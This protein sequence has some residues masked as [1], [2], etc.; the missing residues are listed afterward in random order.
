MAAI[1]LVG[2]LFLGVCG[3]PADP[4]SVEVS[5]LPSYNP[6]A[7][8]VNVA[9]NTL[10]VCP[11]T[12]GV[13]NDSAVVFTN[14]IDL[15]S[16]G[17]FGSSSIV[18]TSA[19]DLI[20]RG[21]A[22]S[23]GASLYLVVQPTP[24]AITMI[25]NGYSPERRYATM[26]AFVCNVMPVESS[27]TQLNVTYAIAEMYSQ[28]GII[29]RSPS[30]KPTVAP[31][32]SPT[33]LPTRF[34]TYAPTRLPTN[35]PTTACS[36]VYANVA[37]YV[38]TVGM[39]P[40]A[41]YCVAEDFVPGTATITTFFGATEGTLD[42]CATECN[43]E[44]T[45]TGFV[46]KGAD[47]CSLTSGHA[48]PGT[49]VYGDVFGAVRLDTYDTLNPTAAPTYS[50]TSTPTTLIAPT[51]APTTATPTNSPTPSNYYGPMT[52]LEC[53]HYME[54]DDIT[55]NLNPVGLFTVAY[56]YAVSMSSDGN[57]LAV[58]MASTDGIVN[59]YGYDNREV[60]SQ[61]GT[62]L[63]ASSSFYFGVSVALAPENSN[64]LV[65][66]MPATSAAPGRAQYFVYDGT[67]WTK[68]GPDLVG[69]G[70]T[71]RFFGTSVA[72]TK[73]GS[74][75]AVGD[76]GSNYVNIYNC[77]ITTGC[78]FVSIISNFEGGSTA[79]FG[80]SIALSDVSI[81]IGSPNYQHD[82]P[83]EGMV[84]YYNMPFDDPTYTEHFGGVTNKGIGA[85][86]TISRDG[87]LYGYTDA[88]G[89]AYVFE[90][91]GG[92]SSPLG[93]T[94]ISVDAAAYYS[95]VKL[96]DDG[97]ILFVGNTGDNS[98]TAYTYVSGDWRL[99]GIPLSPELGGLNYRGASIAASY[100]GTTVVSG[101]A[102]RNA[103]Y[104]NEG[105]SVYRQDSSDNSG[106]A[107]KYADSG[108]DVA[109]RRYCCAPY[110]NCNEFFV[111]GG[112]YNG[113][114]CPSTPTESRISNNSEPCVYCIV[115]NEIT[116]MYCGNTAGCNGTYHC[117]TSA[118]VVYDACVLDYTT[119]A[120]TPSTTLSPTSVPTFRIDVDPTS[121]TC[122]TFVLPNATNLTTFPTC[123]NNDYSERSSVGTYNQHTW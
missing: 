59:V 76:P 105:I 75:V 65:V 25:L 102:R 88:N 30:A 2:A 104:E 66:G 106:W 22:S 117:P 57:T 7:L 18:W 113:C 43:D 6:W 82:H 60:W 45:C 118:L 16:T 49:K 1:F 92:S 93:S 81:V 61:I 13:W 94:I 116:M 17:I 89:G 55:F 71:G 42:Y 120:P 56:P 5:T 85:S 87:T 50:P 15:P 27:T 122:W 26:S 24:D 108:F 119:M 114:A 34:P 12:G 37:P 111:Y 72:I 62:S 77:N 107:I 123:T 95:S 14:D 19:Y 97:S 80:F 3:N 101:S 83:G 100:N 9:A 110:S 4:S 73:N 103:P 38:A 40:L 67:A 112:G 23:S 44:P 46:I 115:E 79:L 47:Y 29:T 20:Q 54:Y 91:T 10:Y 86:V 70:I 121:T 8:A 68:P 41:G 21:Q 90:R 84:G 33:F 35:A 98:V 11:S 63:Y 39:P 58:G 109:V 32:A 52:E 99:T 31:T 51:P 28:C 78:V 64:I 53:V 69:V 36:V 48:T 74:V 96:S